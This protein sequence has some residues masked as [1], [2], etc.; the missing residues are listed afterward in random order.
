MFMLSRQKNNFFSQ[1]YFKEHIAA[2][3]N[4]IFDEYNLTPC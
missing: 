1:V 2:N 4:R 3:L